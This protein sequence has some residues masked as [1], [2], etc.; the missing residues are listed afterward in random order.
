LFIV[1]AVEFL[2]KQDLP[3]RGDN[4]IKWIFPMKASIE[5]IL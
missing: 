4:M 5:A 3:F 2:T 1:L